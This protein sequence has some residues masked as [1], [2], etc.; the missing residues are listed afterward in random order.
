MKLSEYSDDELVDELKHREIKIEIPGNADAEE[1]DID[2]RPHCYECGTI[3]SS[4][5][6]IKI[7]GVVFDLNKR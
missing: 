2:D 4:I 7:G 3:C 5:E 6:K 1:F